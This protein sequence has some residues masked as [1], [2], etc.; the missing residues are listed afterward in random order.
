M[1]KMIAISALGLASY[2][3]SGCVTTAVV[4]GAT[5]G[6]AVVYDQRPITTQVTDQ[7]KRLAVVH[8]LSH[9]PSIHDNSHIST[10]VFDDVLLLTGETTKDEY[11][12]M[13]V[14]QARNAADFKRI[15]NRI[16]I[17]KPAAWA[18][19]GDDTWLTTK[20]KAAMISE[21]GLHSSQIKVVTESRTVYLMGIVSRHQAELATNVTRQIPGV[22]RVIKLFEYTS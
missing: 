1:K 11:R 21:K 22:K 6:G 16:E 4:C 9:T 10:S 2:A 14:Q 12:T 20:I 5:A 3:M 13:A 15:Y 7:K 17:A 8:K 18:E 19:I